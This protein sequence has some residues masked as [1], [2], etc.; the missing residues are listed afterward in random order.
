M[1]VHPHVTMSRRTP[2]SNAGMTFGPQ[3]GCEFSHVWNSPRRSR[4]ERVPGCFRPR[5]LR[6]GLKVT[7]SMGRSRAEA[8][9]PRVRGPQLRYAACISTFVFIVFFLFYFV[10]FFFVFPWVC[11][12]PPGARA[13]RA[14]AISSMFCSRQPSWSTRFCRC[15][16]SAVTRPRRSS[17]TRWM[18][19][20]P[21]VFALF[22]FFSWGF[23]APPSFFSRGVSQHPVFCGFF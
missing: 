3:R 2:A 9:P 12:P 10:S 6:Q 1:N 22:F 20:S 17:R 8:S 14:D 13:A 19:A 23:L 21:S 11:P 15:A 16:P 5:R 4:H 18:A 7:R